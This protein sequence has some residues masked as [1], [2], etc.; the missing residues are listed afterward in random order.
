MWFANTIAYTT[1]N[2]WQTVILFLLIVALN[3]YITITT[4]P[5]APGFGFVV[6]TLGTIVGVICGVVQI[7]EQKNDAFNAILACLSQS[8]TLL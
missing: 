6:G 5:S 1:N 4:G 2:L 7:G 8:M 3:Y